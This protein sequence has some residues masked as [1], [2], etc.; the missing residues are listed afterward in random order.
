MDTLKKIFPY[1]FGVD[2]G[3]ALAVKIIVY[4]VASFVIGLVLSLVT[5]LVAFIP[6]LGAILSTILGIVSWLVGVYCL[7]GLVL[8]ILDFLKV[9]K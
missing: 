3:K 1:S 6:V 7:V 9:F 4:I 2:S 5:L 8:V